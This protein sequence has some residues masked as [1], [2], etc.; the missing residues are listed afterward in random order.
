M[1]ARRRTAESH[2]HHPVE[3]G[4][5]GEMASLTAGCWPRLWAG[6]ALTTG[7][8]VREIVGIP[9]SMRRVIMITQTAPHCTVQCGH[10]RLLDDCKGR[11]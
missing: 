7:Q 5:V 4:D 11:L 10:G 3:C 8:R 1:L 2:R 6:W 9:V